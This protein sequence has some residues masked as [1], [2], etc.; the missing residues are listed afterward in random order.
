[1]KRLGAAHPPTGQKVDVHVVHNLAS[2]WAA[3]H[4]Q[5]I[6]ALGQSLG[7]TDRAGRE[8]TAA[9]D[10]GIL[11]LHRH[12]RGDVALGHDEEMDRRL[13]VDILEGQNRI[14]L[15]LDVRV[16]L[17]RDDATERAVLH[18][19]PPSAACYNNSAWIRT[20][21]RS[22]DGNVSE[23]QAENSQER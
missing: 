11:A 5:P 17:T 22:A 8:K 21:K 18:D 19:A 15:V 14:V 12:D 4:S 23:V 10:L 7:L 1:M 13:R 9:E 20:R 2:L 6:P 16:T 3:V